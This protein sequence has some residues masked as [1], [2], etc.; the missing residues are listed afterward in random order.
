MSM[1]LIMMRQRIDPMEVLNQALAVDKRLTDKA[2]GHS[3]RT[4]QRGQPEC[5][6]RI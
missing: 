4:P 2:E 1:G 6:H 5:L 3:Q